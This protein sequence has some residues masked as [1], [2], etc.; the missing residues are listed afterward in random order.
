MKSIS[1]PRLPIEIYTSQEIMSTNDFR[2]K[3]LQKPLPLHARNKACP[4]PATN[5][6]RVRMVE[7]LGSRAIMVEWERKSNDLKTNQ[8]Q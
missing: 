8:A 2:K 6:L 3:T 1:K 4:I 7:G 5:H